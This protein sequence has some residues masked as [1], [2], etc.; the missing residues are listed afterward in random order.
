VNDSSRQWILVRHAHA[1]WP[2]FSGRDFDRPL[3]QR[4][5]A[6]AHTSACALRDAGLRPELV[7]ASPALRT[8]Q[9]AEILC[10]GLQLP[11]Q[12]LCFPDA[13]YNAGPALLE[14]ELR[15]LQGDRKVVMV[16]AHNPGI[17]ELARRL[18][19]DPLAPAFAPAQWRVLTPAG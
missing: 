16:V 11:P 10:A 12:A 18:S 9:T 3:T 6:D 5:Q 15:K 14:A 17:S 2:S 4:G 8:R 7:V 1:D 13:L 19:K